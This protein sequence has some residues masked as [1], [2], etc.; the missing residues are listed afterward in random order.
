MEEIVHETSEWMDGE[1][2]EIGIHMLV[3]QEMLPPEKGSII[4]VL[5]HTGIHVAVA[6]Y[7]LFLKADFL[8][9]LFLG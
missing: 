4:L 2:A 9:S 7:T 1:N 8:Y 5:V 3:S 6:L